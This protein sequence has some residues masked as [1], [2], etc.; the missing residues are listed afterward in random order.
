MIT[1][2]VRRIVPLVGLA[3]TLLLL[4]RQQ[5]VPPVNS[6]AYVHLRLGDE[7]LS[8]WSLRQPGNLSRFDT[9]TWF[10]SQWLSQ[11]A[12]AWTNDTFGIPGVIW[13]AGALIVSL[14][15]SMYLVCRSTAA[16][17]PAVLAVVVGTC[18][19]APG[20]AA[21]P[22][23]LSYLLTLWVT[24]AWLAT[25]QDKRPRYWLILLAWA[26]VPLHGMWVIG[27]TIG[28]AAVVGIALT[29]SIDGLHIVRLASIALLSALV[30]MVTPLGINAY[31][32]VL[33]VNERSSYLSEWQPPTFTSPNALA[34]LLMIVVILISALRSGAME[35][36]HI[37]ILGLAIAWGLFSVRTTIV[38]AVIL[39]PLAALALQRLVPRVERI[40]A[41]EFLAVATVWLFALGSLA[42]SATTRGHDEPMAGWVNDRL[43]SMPADTA[44]LNDWEVG[45][46][47][48][49]RHPQ[50]QLV[51]H[52][53]VDMF[54]LKELRRN[55]DIVR[56]EPHWDDEIA[57][58]DVEYALVD[59]DSR[60]GYAL[61]ET[62]HWH[63]IESD[64]K[65]A[66]LAPAGK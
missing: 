10:P 21:R 58:L 41:K 66:L 33:G 14:P 13:L 62:L 54:T 27:T 22:Q 56:L 30:P 39:T 42:Y 12:M 6:D 16:P 55:A 37:M 52:G 40:A 9:A 20:L 49:W 36:P 5:H 7:F 11:I 43:D 53:Y 65:Y 29:K 3:C 8:G 35:W 15:V 4:V 64:E 38:A 19:A 24:S 34:L 23:I 1:F 25:A 59:T 47:L 60:L 50:L 61:I 26:W 57:R 28:I 32:S 51:M 18:A 45:H 2:C 63:V 48:L 46:Y 17:L 31:S 44:I